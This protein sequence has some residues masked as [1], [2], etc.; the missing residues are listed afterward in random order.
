MLIHRI[1]H[2][3]RY[4][5]WTTPEYYQ[6]VI[7]NVQNNE[8]KRNKTIE[9]ERRREKLKQLIDSEKEQYANELKG[10]LD[11]HFKECKQKHTFLLV[12]SHTIELSKPKARRVSTEKL[13]GIHE[14]FKRTDE[15]KRRLELESQ[16]Y[17]RWRPSS[18]EENILLSSR[19]NNEA[20]AKMNWLDK[21]V[22]F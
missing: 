15:E 19:S 2:N 17:K 9:L 16:L 3:C 7:S 13:R 5:Q 22:T 8:E 11:K 18:G 4:E 1:L 21:Q 14:V 6:T 10:K 20:L 12:I